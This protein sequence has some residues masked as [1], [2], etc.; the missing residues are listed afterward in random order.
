ML[1]A[2]SEWRE[3]QQAVRRRSSGEG[4]LVSIHGPVQ[5]QDGQVQERVAAEADG[6][7]GQGEFFPGR[8]PLGLS[9]YADF[10]CF[11]DR[12]AKQKA[13]ETGKRKRA[14]ADGDDP[15]EG[16]S[17][18]LSK[19]KD[20]DDESSAE[21]SDSEDSDYMDPN[22]PPTLRPRR[23]RQRYAESASDDDDEDSG[24][25][26]F[27]PFESAE[28]GS[29][30]DR[31]AVVSDDDESEVEESEISPTAQRKGKGRKEKKTKGA[32]TASGS[33]NTGG[34]LDFSLPA[35]FKNPHGPKKKGEKRKTDAAHLDRDSAE[36]TPSGKTK[37]AKQSSPLEDGH[38]LIV[39]AGIIGLFTAYELATRC[40]KD[41]ISHTIT[42]VE[43]RAGVCD[44]AS[45]QCAG[46]LSARG[47]SGDED[48]KS[49]FLEAEEG[50]RAIKQKV[51]GESGADIGLVTEKTYFAEDAGES[52]V[53][54]LEMPG[55]FKP[56]AILFVS[57]EGRYR[58]RIDT[59]LMGRWLLQQCLE[60]GVEFMFGQCVEA[61]QP[62]SAGKGWSVSIG[63]PDQPFSDESTMLEVSNIVIA[64]GPF[65]TSVARYVFNNGEVTGLGNRHQQHLWIEVPLNADEDSEVGITVKTTDD[66]SAGALGMVVR[67][68][69]T[70]IEIS[71]AE[72]QTVNAEFG[73]QFAR[74]P[75]AIDTTPLE[76]LAGE[77]LGIR[78]GSQLQVSSRGGGTVSVGKGRKPYVGLLRMR[79]EGSREKVEMPGVWLSYGFGRFGTTLAPGAARTLVKGMMGE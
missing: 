39:G 5:S 53:E 45:G 24:S 8:C 64:A 35:G 38:T 29:R 77:Y 12:A 32:P 19:R 79:S 62:S 47:M 54:G 20:S 59:R 1:L 66:W 51:H 78:R 58:D 50:W 22:H 63:N 68:G 44:L 10:V 60:L 55:W 9:S 73:P 48:W 69:G 41:G 40:R 42:V 74:N 23:E 13:I 37:K 6:A 75:P 30:R 57:E 25:D 65:T 46:F 26:V 34:G 27:D 52:D 33:T 76:D 15:G 14:A 2:R 28:P 3:L 70:A 7:D 43:I 18:K 11:Q 56:K 16:S 71:A 61:A 31:P 17:K 36:T 72:R 21:P 4:V 49:L 67:P